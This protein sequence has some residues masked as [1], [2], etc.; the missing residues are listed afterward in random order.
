MKLV[1]VHELENVAVDY[2][3]RHKNCPLTIGEFKLI[4]NFLFEYPAVD[5]IPVYWIKAHMAQRGTFVRRAYE[6]MLEEWERAKE[7]GA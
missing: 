3:E 4:V 5:A 7:A 1:D 6:K 2:Q